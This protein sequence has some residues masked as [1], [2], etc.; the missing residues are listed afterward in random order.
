MPHWKDCSPGRPGASR[1]RTTPTP[2]PDTWPH[3]WR[4]RRPWPGPSGLSATGVALLADK[5]REELLVLVSLQGSRPTWRAAFRG[6]S[7]R[8]DGLDILTADPKGPNIRVLAGLLPDALP[9]PLGLRPSFGFGDRLGLAT[10]GHAKALASRAQDI[11]PIFCQQSIREME[12]TGRSAAMVMDDALRGAFRAGWTG[13]CGADAD[14]LKTPADVDVTA[15]E[16]FCFFTIDPSDHVD[17]HVDDDA[18]GRVEEKFQALIDDKVEGASDFLALYKGQRYT[19]K[20]G[21]GTE[22]VTLDEAALKRAAVKYGRALAHI[23]AMALHIGATM[24]ERP[25]EIEVS[26]DET[27]QPTSV[28]E[29]LFIALELR[30]RDVPVVS[31][32]PRFVGR[33]EKGV[34]YIGDPRELRRTMAL[35]AAVARRCGP[36]KLSLHSGSDKFSVYPHLGALSGGLFHVKTAGT[37]YLEALRAAARTDAEFFRDVV[38]FCRDRYRTDRAT[39]HVS[40]ELDMAGDPS[41]LSPGEMEQVYLNDDPGRQILHVTFGSVLT[42]RGADGAPLFRE[43]LM[44]ILESNRNLYDDMLE[45]HF[46][47]HLRPLLDG[48]AQ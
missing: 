11:L 29:H 36:Y 9:R 27:E 39:Y 33:F 41:V 44:D 46:A 15:A 34:D 35:H 13:P 31:L 10:T 28:A 17:Q 40:A 30:R 6:R 1:T 43:R 20:T 19:L 3:A 12:R 42:T 38:S 23:R 4:G 47:A 8:G 48:T 16:G 2:W 21:Q 45:R 32:A 5:G 24:G 22:T 14:H 26:V 25:W 37:S 18:P 7:G